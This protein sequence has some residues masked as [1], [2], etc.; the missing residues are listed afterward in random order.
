[1]SAVYCVRHCFVFF[2]GLSRLN[3]TLTSLD[4]NYFT[5]THTHTL[6]KNKKAQRN[7]ETSSGSLSKE[8]VAGSRIQT[9]AQE[10]TIKVNTWSSLVAQRVKYP[11]LSLQRPGSS[12]VPGLGTSTCHRHGRTSML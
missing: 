6:S 5:H 10:E 4:R 3:F 12:S 1:M 7:E 9:E 8:V 2:M 11:V